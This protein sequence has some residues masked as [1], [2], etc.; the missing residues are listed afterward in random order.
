VATITTRLLG[1]DREKRIAIFLLGLAIPCSAQLGVISGLLAKVGPA[2]VLLYGAV[3]FTILVLTGSL[4]KMIIPGRTTDLLIDLPAIRLPR[5][6]NV[7]KKTAV[8]SWAF[9][10]E[11]APLFALGSLIISIFRIAGWLEMLQRLLGPLTKGWL[12]LP[13]Q[14]ATA[15]I[16]GIVRRDFGAAGLSSMAMTPLQTVVSLITITLFVPCLASV[17]IMFKE[18]SKQEAVTMWLSTWVI[19]FAVG[20]IIN[21]LSQAFHGNILWMI[22]TFL[23]GAAGVIWVTKKL[24]TAQVSEVT[25][26][27]NN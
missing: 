24:T 10:I 3:L 17:M 14:A 11:A 27:F 5:A 9:I 23:A 16:M 4:L 6:E 25:E 22:V 8:K 26:K 2:Y 21:Q 20:G 1:S 13:V 18:R 7:L 19:A 12:G 15:F